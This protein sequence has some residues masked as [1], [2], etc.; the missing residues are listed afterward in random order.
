M[1]VGMAALKSGA[2]DAN[3]RVF[4]PGHIEFGNATFHCWRKGGHDTMR[5]VSALEE[6]CDVF[7]YEAARRNGVDKIAEMAKRFGPGD[8]T[9]IALTGERQMG[10][11][12][13]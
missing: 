1:M 2:I 6:S 11:A 7:F 8:D 3:T 4:C 13:V 10:R 12:H 5:V 9:G